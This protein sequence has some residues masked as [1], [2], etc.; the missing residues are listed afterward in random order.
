V[1]ENSIS[2]GYIGTDMTKRG[3]ANAEW[4]Q[5][6]LQCTPMGRVGE[7][8]EVASAVL[9]LASDARSYFTGSNLV[10]DGGYTCW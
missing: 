6:W 4:R 5:A 1:R 8:S 9:F 3:M 10:L 2:P 7:V